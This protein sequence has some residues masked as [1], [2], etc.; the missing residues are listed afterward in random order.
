[1]QTERATYNGNKKRIQ[2]AVANLKPGDYIRLR[3]LTPRESLRL[4]GID[5]KHIDRML[6]ESHNDESEIFK[7]AG[8][9][10]IVDVM[11]GIFRRLFVDRIGP[12]EGQ[13]YTLY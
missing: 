5:D 2:E 13:S 12:D 4:M 7:Q 10:I 3:R 6:Y 8:N 1:M 9:S 11:V